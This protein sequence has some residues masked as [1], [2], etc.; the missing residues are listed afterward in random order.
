ML[1]AQPKLGGGGRSNHHGH[2]QLA[3][4]EVSHLGSL[5][6][7]GVEN[8]RREIHEFDLDDGA[9]SSDRQADAKTSRCRLRKGP[10]SDAFFPKLLE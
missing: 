5:V 6:D 4:V 7:D 3:P 2:F 10:I 8:Q 9:H 1:C